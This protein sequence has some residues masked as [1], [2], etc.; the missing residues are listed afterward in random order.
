MP[1]FNL[2]PTPGTVIHLDSD[3]T[4]TVEAKLAEGDFADI[5]RCTYDGPP[6]A[7]VVPESVEE[8]DHTDAH[9]TRWDVLRAHWAP[10]EGEEAEEGDETAAVIKVARLEADNDLI[11]AEAKALRHLGR[12][13]EGQ[14]HL[15]LAE[16]LVDSFT[17]RG[18]AANVLPFLG[19]FG[20]HTLAE[21]HLAYAD[22]IDYRDFAWMFK[23]A[24]VV[25]GW[26]HHK[27]LIHGSVIPPHI[28]VHPTGH[29]AKLI[30]WCYSVPY[31][32]KT[33]IK[34]ISGPYR[35]FVPPEVFAKR[36]PLPSTDLYMLA[37][38]GV[39]LLGGNVETNEMPDSVPAE[40]QD[41]LHACLVESPSARPL[42]AWGLHDRFDKILQ[43]LV[44][45]PRYRPFSLSPRS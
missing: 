6:P 4:L 30:D 18:R 34:A 31:E 9:R 17:L 33:S 42:D 35:A 26:A 38:C 19:G 29:G 20:F 13:R 27:G 8:D 41:M 37:K 24:L 28:F 11:E 10:L 32:G 21:V 5:Y 22:G 45:R 40:V 14:F 3:R 39:V 2:D 44:G 25:L 7:P 36:F 43:K 16:P 1:D 15:Y 12:H 23:R